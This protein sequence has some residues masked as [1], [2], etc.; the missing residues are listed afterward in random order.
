MNTQG[1]L[2][3][4]ALEESYRPRC[5]RARVVSVA[6]FSGTPRITG[7]LAVPFPATRRQG[8]VWS[9]PPAPAAF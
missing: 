5:L 4:A 6:G 3:A 8:G 2:G 1:E 9:I 7:G